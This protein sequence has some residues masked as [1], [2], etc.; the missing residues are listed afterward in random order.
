MGAV[1][2]T[3]GG[4]AV[5]VR[6]S[7]VWSVSHSP[8]HL[9]QPGISCVGTRAATPRRAIGPTSSASGGATSSGIVLVVVLRNNDANT[10]SNGSKDEK[11]DS[12]ADDLRGK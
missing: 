2:L 8:K 1:L 4:G 12:S 7:E 11:N 3:L 10:Y 6:Q 9:F 5:V